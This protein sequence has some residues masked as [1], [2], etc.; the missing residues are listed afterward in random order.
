MDL[1][2]LDL[3]A[4]GIRKTLADA[5]GNDKALLEKG[6]AEVLQKKKDMSDHHPGFGRRVFDYHVKSDRWEP[7][8]PSPIPSQVT[9]L[10]VPWEGTWV[11]ANGEVRPGIRTPRVTTVSVSSP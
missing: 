3:E 1:E 9:T 6:L 10:A 8:A 2:G 4:A 7:L 11:V 5:T